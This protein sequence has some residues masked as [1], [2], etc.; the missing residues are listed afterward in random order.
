MLLAKM[1]L[2]PYVSVHGLGSYVVGPDGYEL[3]NPKDINV[4]TYSNSA[5][6][7]EISYSAL[8]SIIS[9]FGTTYQDEKQRVMDAVYKQDPSIRLETMKAMERELDGEEPINSTL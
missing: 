6:I 8:C 7:A 5:P 1:N 9:E 3:T 2:K 4:T